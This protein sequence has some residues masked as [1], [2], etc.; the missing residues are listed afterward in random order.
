MC[1]HITI[2]GIRESKD[3]RYYIDQY[4]LYI[5]YTHQKDNEHLN[6]VFRRHIS[7][8]QRGIHNKLIYNQRPL[9]YITFLARFYLPEIFLYRKNF[10]L[11]IKILLKTAYLKIFIAHL[12]NFSG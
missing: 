1:E 4:M 6:L 2:D 10:V 3:Y 9:L 8:S 12:N 11:G 5:C 7:S